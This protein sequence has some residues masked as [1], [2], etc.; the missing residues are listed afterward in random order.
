MRKVFVAII[1]LPLLALTACGDDDAKVVERNMTKAAQNYEIFRRVILYN[2]ILDKN[3]MITEGW[4]NVEP[5]QL[6]TSVSCKVGPNKY[7]RHFYGNSDNS[8]YIV[9]QLEASSVNAYHYRRTF[10]PQVIIPDIDFRGS[11]AAL[12]ENHGDQ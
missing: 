2:V 7:L 12:I 1:M 9:E 11:G 10:K 8:L 4:C 6:R 5:G 3:V